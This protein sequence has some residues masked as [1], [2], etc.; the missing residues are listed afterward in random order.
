[1]GCHGIQALEDFDTSSKVS[2]KGTV[3]LSLFSYPLLTK[4]K[5]ESLA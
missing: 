4:D 1:M 3:W 2:S 5:N